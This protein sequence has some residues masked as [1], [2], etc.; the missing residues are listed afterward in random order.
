MA[1]ERMTAKKV[2]ISDIV[3]GRWVKNEGLE[4]SYIVTGFGE[5]VS[6]AR[7]MATVVAKF[8]AEDG[9]FGSITLDDSTDTIR[10]KTFKTVKP[11][12][13]VE[14]GEIVDLV[15]KVREYNGELYIIPES[16]FKVKDPNMELLRR[17]EIQKA[18][19][20]A[21][22]KPAAAAQQQEETGK[23]E[24]TRKKVLG[25]IE[26]S[27]AG[28]TYN[29]ILKAVDAPEPEIE[30]IIDELLSE[31]VCYEPMPGRIRKI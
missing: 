16:V 2:R 25:V 12:E 10:A 8:L 5:Q 9:N 1:I 19:R 29:E 15:G 6:R 23:V 28:A 17:L 7:V 3:S 27:K 31:G 4:P 14:I 13:K 30:S 21:N 18:V 20:S 24:E 26:S 22:L 11:L